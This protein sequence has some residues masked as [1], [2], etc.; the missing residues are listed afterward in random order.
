[1]NDYEIKRNGDGYPDPT[2]YAVLKKEDEEYERFHKLLN[3]I[4]YIC[5]MAEFHIE[6]RIVIKDLRTGRIWK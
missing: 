5:E 2:A 1:M 3:T 4:F 6:E